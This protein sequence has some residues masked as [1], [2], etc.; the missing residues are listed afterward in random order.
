MKIT[1]DETGEAMADVK[2]ES[3]VRHMIRHECDIHTSQLLVFDW[4]RAVLH[5]IPV[6]E[7]PQ[8]EW[9]VYGKSITM[10]DDL[11]SFEAWADPRAQISE[12]ALMILL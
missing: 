5:D 12:K 8:V 3:Y 11:R 1:L 7:R 9:F 2:V 4:A 10:D 6:K